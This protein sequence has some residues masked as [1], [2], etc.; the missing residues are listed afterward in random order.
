MVKIHFPDIPLFPVGDVEPQPL[1]HTAHHLRGLDHIALV[2]QVGLPRLEPQIGKNDFRDL[3][4]LLLVIPQHDA[5]GLLVQIP[6]P[7]ADEISQPPAQQGARQNPGP[8]PPG[9]GKNE[10]EGKNIVVLRLYH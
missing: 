1:H 3:G 8:I 6:L 9:R 10:P 5:G 7:G 4:I 2:R